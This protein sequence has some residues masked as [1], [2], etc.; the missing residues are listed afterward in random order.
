MLVVENDQV[1]LIDQN[2]FKDEAVFDLLRTPDHV[3]YAVYQS[4]GRKS[5]V[6]VIDGY[7]EA[8]S[9]YTWLDPDTLKIIHRCTY[10]PAPNYWHHIYFRSFADDGSIVELDTDDTCFFTK[11]TEKMAEKENYWI[12]EGQYCSAKKRITP[13]RMQPIDAL[14]FDRETAFFSNNR[15]DDDARSIVVYDQTGSLID[16]IPALD[17]EIK[18]RGSVTVSED[19]GRVAIIVD[20][21]A[22][23]HPSL[24]ISDHVGSRR[25]DI[26]DTKTWT[27][28][29]QIELP[30]AGKTEFAS[31]TALAFTPD[32]KTLA[33]RMADLVQFYDGIP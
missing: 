19:G 29:A 15:I 5:L 21:M 27:R 18:E 30:V 26:Y 14:V 20:T 11:C 31:G 17:R 7:V 2:R 28:T 4:P 6:V 22:G 16:A 8:E 13:E 1:H 10:P 32:G 25:V 24:D 9:S 23:G 3:I 33:I 12:A